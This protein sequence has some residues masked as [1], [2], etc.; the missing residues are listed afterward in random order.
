MA[1]NNDSDEDDYTDLFNELGI[2]IAF[3]QVVVHTADKTKK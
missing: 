3:P 2:E 1:V